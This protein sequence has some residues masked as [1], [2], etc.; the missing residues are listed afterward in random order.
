M[1]DSVYV[2][3]SIN[4]DLMIASDR[5]PEQGETIAG[6]DYFEA[7]GGKGGNQ[8]AACAKLGCDTNLIGSVGNDFHGDLA[9]KGLESL[10]VNTKFVKRSQCEST[11]KAIIIK[12]D[13][14][15]R[16][17]INQGANGDINTDM[18]S[19]ALKNADQQFFLTQFEMPLEFI[20]EGLVIAKEKN[21]VTVVNPA[22]AVAVDLKFYNLI[23]YLIVNQSESEILTG[24]FPTTIND[25]KKAASILLERGVKNIVFTLGGKGSIYISKDIILEIKSYPVEVIDTTGAG[26][27]YIGT[28]M[29]GLS[30]GWGIEKTLTFSSAAGALACT[31]KG[32]QEALPT[33][34]EL[35]KFM[36]QGGYDE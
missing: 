6:Y 23:D 27:A 16:I 29:Y 7:I 14:D 20:Y 9:V 36:T 35:V 22:P 19:A 25:C 18:I 17:I 32:A 4:F 5:M 24:I 1:R 30:N 28:M 2:L 12:T 10:G 3:G 33:Y 11:G 13:N 8:A 31:K 26:D 21:M 15:N 34:D